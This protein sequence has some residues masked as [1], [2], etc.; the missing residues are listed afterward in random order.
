[1]PKST[2]TISRLRN[3][4]HACGRKKRSR[5]TSFIV[6]SGALKGK[7]TILIKTIDRKAVAMESNSTLSKSLARYTTRLSMGPRDRAKRRN[8]EAT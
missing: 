1:M 7:F 4:G 6:S 5:L 3:M 2:E 8:H